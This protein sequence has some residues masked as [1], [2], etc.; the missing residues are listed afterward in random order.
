MFS[1]DSSAIFAAQIKVPLESSNVYEV[2]NSTDIVTKI[3]LVNGK[4]TV[5]YP[6]TQKLNE[7]F[8]KAVTAEADKW[9]APSS[10]FPFYLETVENG[11]KH[12]NISYDSSKTPFNLSKGKPSENLHS[13][14]TTAL[15]VFFPNFINDKQLSEFINKN[16]TQKAHILKTL[17]SVKIPDHFPSYHKKNKSD[18]SLSFF[19]TETNELVLCLDLL[20]KGAHKKVN[21]TYNLNE[22]AK[23]EDFVKV[24]IDKA[25]Y[26]TLV[27][28]EALIRELSKDNP[29]LYYPKSERQIVE[30]TTNKKTTKIV[31][32]EE[33]VSDLKAYKDAD[34]YL[35]RKWL[36]QI[37]E[38]LIL[39]HE[40]GFGHGDLKPSNIFI[41]NGEAKIA[42][43]DSLGQIGDVENLRTKKYFKLEQ[44]KT[45]TKNRDAQALGVSIFDMILPI[46]VMVYIHNP[47][48]FVSLKED[49][50][51]SIDDSSKESKMKI[52]L[53]RIAEKLFSDQIDLPKALE[54][55]RKL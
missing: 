13:L 51:R 33:K 19:I 52:L 32:L 43:F 53:I 42:D 54:E 2:T 55:I 7:T 24:Q 22:S 5:D 46:N 44:S 39:L 11:V 50:L 29:Y 12:L 16:P 9:Q 26:E 41:V 28:K 31:Y 18:G 14:A 27:G 10:C 3:D 37:T 21:R 25:A 34:I 47:S 48:L 40:E 4:S 45:L 35:L 49:Y 17:E 23:P 30:V 8:K 36:E 38:G 15:R 6:F 1:W 20:A